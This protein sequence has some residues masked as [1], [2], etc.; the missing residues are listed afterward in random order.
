MISIENQEY[1]DLLNY[2]ISHGILNLDSVRD[3]MQKEERNKY[4]SKHTYRIFQDKDGRWKTT[5]PDETK[6]SGRRLVAK[7]NRNDLEDEIIEFYKDKE[8]A[9][10]AKKRYS[11]DITL[12]ELY[13]IWLQSRMLEVNNVRTVKRN[14]QDWKRY[15]LGT[16]IT[17]KP[18]A[19]MTP[20][21]LK[22]WAH[23]MIDKYKFNKRSY[24]NMALIM[25]KCYEY[26]EDEGICDNI[27]RKVK[28]NTSKFK[29]TLKPT[30]ETQIYF[31]D[32][33]EKIIRCCLQSFALRPWNIGVMAIPLLFCTGM[34]IGEVVALKYEDLAENEIFVRREEVNDYSFDEKKNK[35]VYH[36]KIV[37]EHTKT[38]AG[39]RKIP[40][41]KSAKQIIALV[42]ESSRYYN[43]SDNG[44][45]FCPASKRLVSNS[46]DN[47]LYSYCEKLGIPM[48]SAHKIRKTYISQLITSGIDL[49]TVCR[50][51]GH[52]DLKTTFQSYLFCLERKDEVYEKFDSMFRE[53]V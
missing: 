31:Q 7:K 49:D 51:S 8:E 43:Y 32:E 2:A 44:Y 14:D 26:L 27:W 40:Y 11:T 25:K 52:T 24:Y 39:I 35:F 10:E 6:K 38:E 15:Y 37:E 12:E 4:L 34:R 46:I 48:K 23:T 28:I 42:R 41:T 29:R 53:I 17:K 18:M 20:N 19:Y 21:E 33:K 5:F 9:N 47:L 3:S 1:Q 45:I 13:P 30:N 36:G 22:D 50:V 16:E